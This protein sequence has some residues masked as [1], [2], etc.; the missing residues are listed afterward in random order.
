MKAFV[1]RQ[2][3]FLYREFMPEETFKSLDIGR[4]IPEFHREFRIK[5]F[6]ELAWISYNGPTYSKEEA[7]EYLKNRYERSVIPIKYTLRTLQANPEFRSMVKRLRAE[8]WLD[9]HILCS[10][11]GIAVNY[12]VLQNFEARRNL[13]IQTTL[14]QALMDDAE[15]PDMAT[16][17]LKEFTEEKIRMQQNV[18]MTSSLKIYNLECHQHTPDFDAIAHFL[19]HRYNYFTDDI[20]HA[21]PFA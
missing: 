12:R 15:T 19:R 10:I 2:Y 8:G 6:S 17:P 4:T 20:P 11:S 14:F 18:T 5:E 16:V 21:D 13:I 9:W 7:N 1:A 3:D